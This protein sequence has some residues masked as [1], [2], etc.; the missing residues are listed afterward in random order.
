MRDHVLISLSVLAVTVLVVSPVAAPAQDL[1]RWTP[2][3][4]GQSKKRDPLAKN[5]CVGCVA[6]PAKPA[7]TWTPPHT[8]WGDPDLQGLW[9]DATIT[10]FQRPNGKLGEKDLLGDEDAEE[11][12]DNISRNRRD[13][14]GTDEDVAR[15]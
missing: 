10:P 3:P 9:N 12:L 13:G 5:G 6:K 14:I 2:K 15:A 1:D 4:E 11:I 8:S 7:K